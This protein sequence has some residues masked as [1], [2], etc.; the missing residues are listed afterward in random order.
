[1][2]IERYFLDQNL[3][4]GQIH[5]LQDNEFHHLAHVMRSKKGQEIDLV[6]GKGSLAKAKILEL[7]KNE[8]IVE[9]LNC[10][11]ISPK[12]KNLILAQAIPKPNRL[13]FILEKGTEL[14]VDQF[15]LFPGELSQKKE[16]FPNQVE[17]AQSLTIAA[18]KQCGR[19]FLP[20]IHIFPPLLDWSPL[21]EGYSA[22]FGDIDPKAPPF[23]DLWDKM[24]S[25]Q[26]FLFITGPE[27]GF[28]QIETE[29][30]RALSFSG[31]KLH[32]NTL[33]TDTASIAALSLMSHWLINLINF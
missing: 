5:A 13:D 33:R 21:E 32:D 7:K 26:N 25:A 24:S 18:M 1:M 17:R 28:N 6:N 23:Q 27:S 12:S 19:L 31:V 16:I 20:Q 4:T 9:V 29:K 14:G 15:W 8:A 22:F 30:L 10:H 2:P 11:S 3:A